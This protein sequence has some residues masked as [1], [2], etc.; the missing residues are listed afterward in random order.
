MAISLTYNQQT[1]VSPAMTPAD[2]QGAR[3]TPAVGEAVESLGQQGV[4]LSSD[5]ARID[6]M[7]QHA[8]EVTQLQ[9]NI[10]QGTEDFDKIGEQLKQEVGPSGVGYAERL[11]DKFHPWA[12]QVLAQ[13]KNPQVQQMAARQLKTMELGLFR[14]ARGWEANTTRAWRVGSFENS[15]NSEAELVGKDP[16]LF[17]PLMNE[18]LDALKNIQGLHPMDSFNLANKVKSTYSEAAMLSDAQNRPQW[19]VNMLQ[20]QQPLADGSIPD[21]IVSAA[22]AKG[23][24]PQAALAIAQFE[25]K[26][27][28]AAVNGSS[29]GLYQAQP[30]FAEQYGIADRTNPDQSI[31][32]AVQSF[33]DNQRAFKD[34][35]KRD[36]TLPELY[37]MHLLGT[38]GGMALARAPNDQPFAELAGKLYGKQADKVQSANH[39]QN[40]TVG[41]VKAQLA[42]WMNGAVSQTAGM[43]NAPSADEA[44]DENQMPPYFRMATPQQRW[45]VMTHAQS[46]LKHDETSDRSTVAQAINDTTAAYLNAQVP[47]Q[48][49]SND[50]IIRAYGPQRGAIE[51]RD[52]DQAQ[53]YGAAKGQLFTQNPDQQMAT[54]AQAKAALDPG[55]PGYAKALNYYNLLANATQEITNQRVENTVDAD[56]GS[57]KLTHALDM[58]NPQLL[59]GQLAAR[60]EQ[61]AQLQ[62]QWRLPSYKPLAKDE[63]QAL[64][65]FL[66]QGKPTE[67]ANYLASFRSAAGQRPE[68]YSAMLQQIAPHDPLLATAGAVATYDQDMAAKI[69]SGRTMM[70]D[71]KLIGVMANS[72]QF[73]TWWNANRGQAFG[74][75]VDSSRMNLDA[76]KAAYAA[77]LPPE[78]RNSKTIDNATMKLVADRIAPVGDFNGPT[79]MPGGMQQ[80][81]FVRE[82]AARYNGAMQKAGKDPNEWRFNLMRMVPVPHADGMYEPYSGTMPTGALIDLNQPPDSVAMPPP[83]PR[84]TATVTVQKKHRMVGR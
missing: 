39:L 51:I 27:N 81:Q 44:P 40:M 60:F 52:L 2:A 47:T 42:G 3:F 17:E 49:P 26:M 23:V 83:E 24:D 74:G 58:S 21:K 15:I 56:R 33:A 34:T 66:Q 72:Q 9:N 13:Q 64:T 73:D 54:L 25:S 71:E 12:Q 63:A 46:I 59:T 65:A 82:L 67:V 7:R 11:L 78:L 32:G 1:D 77:M 22:K 43:A 80:D 79:L 5:I 6:Y 70:K 75:M 4:R 10:T 29:V 35:L 36:P 38:G 28:P 20:G 50:A 30:A 18:K 61:V 76:A 31:K 53:A 62:D 68:R 19:T 8:N 84:V 45:A 37:A 14:E 48:R 69:V 16:S 55:A 57:L 41:Q